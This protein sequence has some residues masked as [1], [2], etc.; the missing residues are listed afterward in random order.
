MICFG[1]CFSLIIQQPLT[2]KSISLRPNQESYQSTEAAIQRE[3][4]KRKLCCRNKRKKKSHT[5]HMN[6]KIYINNNNSL[7]SKQ[8]SFV[9]SL[10]GLV[11]KYCWKYWHLPK[12]AV[13]PVCHSYKLFSLWSQFLLCW[14]RLAWKCHQHIW[15]G[16]MFYPHCCCQWSGVW[17][18][19]QNS[20]P[21]YLSACIWHLL[22]KPSGKKR[23]NIIKR[24]FSTCFL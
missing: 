21:R 24:Q 14:Q 4:K 20:D 9:I 11:I 5:K 18:C 8:A 7:I 15:R 13:S 6:N 19:N 2:L 16:R 17:T 23:T 1:F 22:L 12:S 10:L 3:L